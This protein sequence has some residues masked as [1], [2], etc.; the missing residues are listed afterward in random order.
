[1]SNFF[2]NDKSYQKARCFVIP[3]ILRKGGALNDAEDVIQEAFITFFKKLSTP[4]FQ[5]TSN[6]ENYIFGASKKIWADKLKKRSLLIDDCTDIEGF[7]EECDGIAEIEERKGKYRDILNRYRN[8]LS[9]KCKQ[10]FKYREEG[11]SCEQ[12]A[13]KMG[14][15]SS[16]ITKN[17]FHLC[18]RRL[19]ELAAE[20]PEYK[21]L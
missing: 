11:L 19:L 1:L 2:I 20:D 14:W 18:K 17:K 15:D 4:G 3:Y 7:E 8:R 16:R 9:E 21:N 12:I 10:V 6:P 5:L 13:E